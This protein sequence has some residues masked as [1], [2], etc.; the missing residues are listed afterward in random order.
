MALIAALREVRRHVIGIRRS[1][2]ILQMAGDARCAREVVIII[3]VAIGALPGRDR[4]HARQRKVGRVVVKRRVRPRCGVVAL[5]AS[6]RKTS[7]HVIRIGGSLIVLEVAAHA[8]R[9][10][11]VVIVVDV[12]IGAHARRH[13]MASSQR[14]SNRV[15]V[16]SR[17]QP[18][19]RPVAEA[20]RRG[21]PARDVARVGG[22]LEICRVAG[23][24]RRRHRLKL[25][26]GCALMA[27]VAVH[28]GVRSCQGKPIVMLLDSLHRDLPAPN[29]VALFA[30][31]PELTPVNIG[32]AVLTA[33]SDVREHGLDVALDARHRPVHAAQRILRLI[34]IEFRNRP[35]RLPR[36]RRVAILTGNVQVSVRTMRSLGNLREPPHSEKCQGQHHN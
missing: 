33:L 17:V 16:E 27:G 29:G 25:A 14:K 1:L 30:T 6:L 7:G 3:D 32:V 13:R 20:A 26:G 12:A 31:R 4:V 2:V 21:E 24:T 19:V 10:G 23:V 22:P 28:C 8:S 34:V 15:V 5:I 9:A 11:Q 18:G 35:N 36:V